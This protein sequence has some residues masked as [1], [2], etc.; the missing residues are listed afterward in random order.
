MKALSKHNPVLGKAGIERSHIPDA[1]SR[2][3][4]IWAEL[5]GI[6]QINYRGS[7]NYPVFTSSDSTTTIFVLC[8]RK[9]G[10]FVLVGDP[11]KSH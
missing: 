4:A 8:T 1:V 7:P 3:V 10:I 2:E 11:L 5:S 6:N 9:W